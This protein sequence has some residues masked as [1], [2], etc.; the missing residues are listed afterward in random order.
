M[1]RFGR[2]TCTLHLVSAPDQPG[3]KRMYH[4]REAKRL[5]SLYV[6]CGIKFVQYY[7]R[8]TN[9]AL[10]LFWTRRSDQPEMDPQKK[11]YIFGVSDDVLIKSFLRSFTNSDEKNERGWFCLQSFRCQ[12]PDALYFIILFKT[13]YM[14]LL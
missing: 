8:F 13:S 14:L 2:P 11:C 5:L 7:C 4:I 12:T 3:R 10:Q 6:Y 1:G 9:R